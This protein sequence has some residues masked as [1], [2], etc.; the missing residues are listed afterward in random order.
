MK[1]SHGG[2]LRAGVRVKLTLEN[3]LEQRGVV[4]WSKDRFA[5]VR[6]ND[7]IPHTRLDSVA[8]LIAI[9]ATIG[10]DE[11]FPEVFANS[12]VGATGFY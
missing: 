11:A 12:D 10:P 4:K 1:I 2:S 7:P 9:S 3:G 8:D 6:F 5:G